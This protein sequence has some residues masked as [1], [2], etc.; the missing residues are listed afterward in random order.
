MIA[1]LSID[2]QRSSYPISAHAA[3]PR[4][5]ANLRFGFYLRPDAVTSQAA[6]EIQHLLAAQYGLRLAASLPPHVTIKGFTKTAAPE[7]ELVARLSAALADWQAFPVAGSGVIPFGPSVAIDL[8]W[9]PDG[10][11]NRALYDLQEAAWSALGDL[12][13]PDC[14]FSPG[15]P[16]GPEAPNPFHPHLTLA[17][18]DVRPEFQQEILDFVRESGRVRPHEFTATHCHLYRLWSNDWL[19]A[20]W[21]SLEWELAHSWRLG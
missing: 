4:S 17:G 3:S 18:P 20:W 10:Q 16:R 1:L 13:A 12:I 9:L 19:G 11:A 7:A 6:A 15:E 21:Q 8:R 2:D 14:E 5:G